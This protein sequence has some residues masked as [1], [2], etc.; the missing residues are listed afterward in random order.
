MSVFG[1]AITPFAKKPERQYRRDF[2]LSLKY[3]DRG[4]DVRE[5]MLGLRWNGFVLADL[6]NNSGSLSP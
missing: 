3:L 2:D 1:S 5:A 6:A 4:V